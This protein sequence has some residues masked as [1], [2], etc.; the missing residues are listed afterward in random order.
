MKKSLAGAE[1]KTFRAN[2]VDVL[3]RS[4]H[5]LNSSPTVMTVGDC[6]NDSR[7]VDSSAVR[8]NV[9]KQKVYIFET[10]WVGRRLG[11]N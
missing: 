6:G 10:L 11:P 9:K 3:L 4:S 8:K 7:A 2:H 5:L 1:K